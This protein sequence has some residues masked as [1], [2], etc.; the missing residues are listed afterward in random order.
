MERFLPDCEV[1]ATVG[2]I[3]DLPRTAEEVP[4]SYK[5]TA[6]GNL[7]INVDDNFKP[8]YVVSKDKKK[9]VTE[10][11]KKINRRKEVYLATDEDREGES[12]SWHIAELANPEVA[13]HR[14]VFHEITPAA[15]KAAIT[16][17]RKINLSLVK[18]QETRRIL[19]RLVGYTV[20]PLLWKKVA[21]KLS[22]GRVQSVVLRMIVERE[23]ERMK[24]VSNRYWSFTAS[25]NHEQKPFHALMRQIGEKQ[26]VQ[27]KD[28]DP[29][30]GKLLNPEKVVVLNEE[31]CKK[32][33][34]ELAE[35]KFTVTDIEKKKLNRNPPPPFI[36]SS[37][38]QE[39]V[40]KLKVNSRN[41]MRLA[42]NLYEKGFITYMRTD[43]SALSAEALLATEKIIEQDY[44]KNYLATKKARPAKKV[45]GAQEAH[46]AIRP[47]GESFK[48]PEKAGLIGLE[49]ELYKL[50]WQRTVASQMKPALMNQTTLHLE[51]K[52]YLFRANGR[53]IEFDGYL[54]VYKSTADLGPTEI[55]PQLKVGQQLTAEDLLYNEHNTEPKARYNEA[56]LIKMMETE[57]IGRP[58]T[59]AAV[60]DTIFMR[61]YIKKKREAI[62]PTITAF[63]VSDL[64]KKHLPDLI[65]T[66]FTA[67]MEQ[68]LDDIAKDG[69]D[70]LEYL[71]KFYSGKQGLNQLVN[72]LNEAIS[73]KDYR[74]VYI[75]TVGSRIKLGRFGPFVQ[76][77]Y[78]GKA[79]SV[80][81]NDD[82]PPAELT[83][84]LLT[85]QAQDNSSSLAGL[86][87]DPD[88]GLT[89]YY[90]VGSYGPYLQI[91]E[92]KDSEN[93]KPKRVGLPHYISH[94]KI[95]LDLAL[96]LIKLPNLLGTHPDTGR[97]I[98]TNIGKYGPYIVHDL[99]DKKD[100]RSLDSL[101]DL[102]E[103]SL[104]QAIKIF[105]SEKRSSNRKPL[106]SLG[107]HP[108]EG[109]PVNIYK[110]PYGIYLRCGKKTAS[111]PSDS[112]YET[113]E[114]TEA[115]K[116][117]DKYRLKPPGR[118]RSYRRKTS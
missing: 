49:A 42:Q 22:A 106:R 67:K 78:E 86:G 100:F 11:L 112:N 92:N 93:R 38:Q 13:M 99:K 82:T 9:L 71:R 36:T 53:D 16:N 89:I 102:W 91:G 25:F 48:H 20:S 33:K 23:K 28:F 51:V 116:L 31:D 37:L 14:M 85:K 40:R 5:G 69:E 1:I 47:A 74:E 115:V 32:I 95:S 75:P 55:L 94:D 110:G 62:F 21:A 39:G 97:K 54:A 81:I 52:N 63:A 103:I 113:I 58:S 17:T 59:Y 44:G 24:F 101:D 105:Q 12:I 66:K 6:W 8:I 83:R 96:K 72:R 80:K 4:E 111:L 27:A 60:I 19:D 114:L 35:E 61:G 50:I 68:K 57:G 46:E 88:S 79:V 65:D 90:L 76:F 64:L 26:L 30:S 84:E 45:K 34:L 107:D 56:S 29:I 41:L 73:P 108:D 98:S 87:A 104:D 118:K 15:L 2:H 18:A 117:I 109:E 43:S 77:D 7:G 70:A 3:R 10:I